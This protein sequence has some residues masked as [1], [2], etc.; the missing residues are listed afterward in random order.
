MQVVRLVALSG[1]FGISL[2]AATFGRVVPLLGGGSDIVLD[3]PHS[4]L[5]LTSAATNQLQVYSL[6]QSKFLSP[7]T[8][9]SEP[10]AAAISRSGQFLYVAC[11]ASSVID[12]IDLTSLAVTNRI[13][14][15]SQPEGIAVASDERVLIS[16][17]GNGTTTITNILLLYDPTPNSPAPLTSLAV[18]PVAPVAPTFPAPS[19]RAHLSAHSQLL[20]T[21]NGAFIVGLHVT[22]ATSGV[23]VVFVYQ[24]SSGTVLRAR[25]L[26]TGFLS[27]LA[28]SDDGSRIL[29]GANLLATSTLQVLGAMNT[30]NFTY[31][32]T[33]I[34]TASNFTT[35]ANQGGAVFSPD[36]ATLYSVYNV[37]PVNS[38]AT[39]NVGQ[40]MTLDPDNL[41]VKMGIQTPEFFAGKMV[42]GADGANAYALSDSGFVALPLST[43]AQ[44]ALAEP[45]VDVLL[46]TNDQCGVSTTSTSTVMLNYP[47]KAKATVSATLLQYAGVTG[48][49]SPATAPTVRSSAT[50]LSFTFNAALA[51]GYG[52]I[53]PPHDFLLESPEAIN[54]PDRVRVY[55]NNR[56]SDDRGTIL[57]I[58][59]GIA[60]TPQLTDLLFDAPRNRI[61]IANTGLNRVEVYD[62]ASGQFLTPIKVGQLPVSLALTPDGTVL[63]VANSGGESISIVDPNAMV[64]TGL[65]AFPPIQFA[66]NLAPILPSTIAAGLSGLQILMSNGQL[67]HVVGN[68]AEPRGVSTI[69]GSSPTTGAPNTIAGGV[70]ATT[71]E[72]RY[73]LVAASNGFVYLYDATVDDFVAGRQLFTTAPIGYAGPIAAGPNG[74]YFLLDGM[75][76]NQALVQVAT[77]TGLI[78]AVAP[79]GASSYAVYSTPASTANALPATQPSVQIL[80]S[81][82]GNPSLEIPALEGPLTQVTAATRAT[83]AG[84]TMAVNPAGT[85]A[86]VITTTG[87]S[88]INL[89]AVSPSARPL[90]NPKGTVN[91]G[92]YQT[93]I[94][95]NS[96][97]SIFGQNLGSSAVAT[98]APLPLILGGT[99]V[100]LNNVA[101]PLFM[102]SPGQIN[103]QIPPATAAGTYPLVVR[104][105][106]NL[107]ES[108]SQ[109]VT[110]SKY[111]PAALVDPTGQLLLFHADGSYVNK[112]NPANRDEPLVMYAVGLGA[113]TGGK[114]LAGTPSP[115]SP[116][117]VSPTAAV[118]FGD[119]SW[120]QAAIIV[121]FAGL[122]PGMIGV[123]QLNLRVPGFHISGDGLLVT[124]TS[125]GVSSPSTGPVVP[126]VSVN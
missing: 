34:T 84:R 20:A 44:S 5:Y 53:N 9:D 47:G 38:T 72:G 30:A 23:G 119:P 45:G 67:W 19:S 87:L 36:G 55:Q 81:T 11:Y 89:T 97:V 117:A 108:A 92:S 90:P 35:Q 80:N 1:L 6:A 21:R 29:C 85:V 83:V 105:I 60:I 86:Y 14:L 17:T 96:L 39:T 120:V 31:P 16:T 24:A 25:T 41:L 48:Q 8:T 10:L 66:S 110:V 28:I 59:T 109:Q 49:A 102:A 7:I 78:S 111:A 75:L 64:S 70:M 37:D 50:Q 27:A 3:E 106:A 65:V 114:V 42:I 95:P 15:P 26:T 46:L 71:P 121:D 124:I 73:I 123:Y 93:A 115:T 91:L 57:P 116:L 98:A 100:T 13:S 79:M 122:A 112:N 94:A 118:Y 82:T 77:A 51:K 32:V 107:A 103:A 63:Y 74:Q 18:T 101:L 43:I 99:C 104:S 40:L 22:N 54:L 62:I 12:V 88:I 113:T 56:D 33:P 61:Y 4:R 76:L 58:A 125:G 2:H 126:T 68:T 52:T 69:I